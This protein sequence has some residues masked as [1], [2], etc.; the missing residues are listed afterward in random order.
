MS[1]KIRCNETGVLYYITEERYDKLVRRYGSDER[2]RAE[3]VSVLGKKIREGS[4]ENR[5]R[6][7]NRVKCSITGLSCY[8]SKS[9]IDKGIA[10]FGS[11]SKFSEVYQCRIA[12][13]LLKQGKSIDDIKEMVLNGT[14]PEK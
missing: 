1:E 3:Y 9:R 12:K 6:H 2:L 13:R 11:W 10:E 14:L 7:T 4:E 5:Q 8:I